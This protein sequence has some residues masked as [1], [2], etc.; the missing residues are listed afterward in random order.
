MADGLVKSTIGF[1]KRS[2]SMAKT[3]TRYQVSLAL[4]RALRS[5][6][7]HRNFSGKFQEE[8]ASLVSKSS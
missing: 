5:G 1:A 7:M 6:P 3:G 8:V 2:K 4:G